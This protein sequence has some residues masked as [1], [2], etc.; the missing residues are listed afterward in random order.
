MCYANQDGA[1]EEKYKWNHE[2]FQRTSRLLVTGK[3]IA[4]LAPGSR[5]MWIRNMAV[6]NRLGGAAS[7]YIC[8]TTKSHIKPQNYYP[9]P[10]FPELR[11]SH[12]DSFH[13]QVGC[14]LYN[15]LKK[16]HDGNNENGVHLLIQILNPHVSG[17]QDSPF[18]FTPSWL[19]SFSRNRKIKSPKQGARISWQVS[20]S[21]EQTPQYSVFHRNVFLS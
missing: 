10:P 5:F 21:W 3:R 19:I 9:F 16:L 6:T 17:P 13:S 20:F 11:G 1:W 12:H 15:F 18:S 7:K 2:R 14:F 8:K 4:R